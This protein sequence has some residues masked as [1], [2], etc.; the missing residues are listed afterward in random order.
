MLPEKMSLNIVEHGTDLI[1]VGYP[2]YLRTPNIFP[3]VQI[4][5]MMVL[6]MIVMKGSLI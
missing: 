3:M 6:Q 1:V 2:P 4:I 5:K